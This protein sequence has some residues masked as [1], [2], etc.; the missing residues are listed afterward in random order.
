MNADWQIDL[1]SAVPAYALALAAG[2]SAKPESLTT[3]GA[4]AT[5]TVT[6]ATNPANLDTVTVGGNV[7]TFVTSGA[8]AHQANI[9]VSATAS[10]DAFVTMFNADTTK[11]LGLVASNVGGNLVFS[12]ATY[13]TTQNGVV[14][15]ENSTHMSI[16]AGSTGVLAGGV[17]AP[18][19]V[20]RKVSGFVVGATALNFN[21]YNG[22][23][24]QEKRLIATSVGAGTGVV[25]YN[26]NVNTVTFSAT[27]QY[28]NLIFL[29]GKWLPQGGTAAFA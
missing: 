7:F 19:S 14:V 24:G 28:A 18:V 3:G 21:L 16:G 2:V 12:T 26:G 23:E 17:D 25:H 10:V 27:G 6:V 1:G 29:G 8:G 15:S 20:N 5:L 13:A 11:N 4:K 22:Y 9:G